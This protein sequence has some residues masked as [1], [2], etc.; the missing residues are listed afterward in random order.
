MTLP[1][2]LAAA[3]VVADVAVAVWHHRASWRYRPPPD[4]ITR[5]RLY[6]LGW[7]IRGLI[8]AVTLPGIVAALLGR[9]PI[10]YLPSVLLLQI[11]GL[12]VADMV[13]PAGVGWRR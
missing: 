11:A 4:G 6:R 1:Y 9:L 7:E 13:A 12:L 3:L 10:A 8:L 5:R 2:V